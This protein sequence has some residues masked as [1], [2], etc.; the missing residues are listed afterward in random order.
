MATFKRQRTSLKNTFF[1]VI[2]W[3]RTYSYL[4]DF[5]GL[6]EAALTD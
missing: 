2:P 6:A 5:T 3:L 1:A 4:S